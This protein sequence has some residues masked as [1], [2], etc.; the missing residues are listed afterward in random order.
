[1]D[2]PVYQYGVKIESETE[3]VKVGSK[4]FK[5][6]KITNADEIYNALAAMDN[7]QDDVTDERIP[8]WTELWPSALALSEFILKNRHLF[9]EHFLFHEIGCGLALPAMVC[10]DMGYGTI[11]SDY[12]K[13][14]LSFALRSR[15]LNGLDTPETFLLDWRHIPKDF[16]RCN[17]LLAADVAY[18]K[19]MFQTVIEVFEKL[20]LPDGLILFAE[21]NR[22]Y[23]KEFYDML[24]VAG[25]SV[26]K[27]ETV[28]E[29]KNFSHHVNVCVI[30]KNHSSE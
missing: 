12:A 7:A 20:T 30:R 13:P 18:E 26:E 15:K 16:Q 10:A 24:M 9:K 1:M 22:G 3:E 2:E 28:V 23:A 29:L 8:Y 21:P 14:A 11:I 27:T 4:T 25:F 6:C 19:R 5:Y 17:V